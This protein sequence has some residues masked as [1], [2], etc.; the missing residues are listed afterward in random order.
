MPSKF[1]LFGLVYIEALSQGKPV[2]YSKGEGID[3]FLT[4]YRAGKAVD[5]DNADAIANGIKEIVKNYKDYTDFDEIVL[6][7]NWDT[8]ASV[9]RKLYIKK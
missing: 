8:I 6:P 2:L 3:G 9:Y 1:E 5:P 7:F 4:N